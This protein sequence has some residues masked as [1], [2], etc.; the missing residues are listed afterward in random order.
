MSRALSSFAFE[1]LRCEQDRD[2]G[3]FVTY[4]LYRLPGLQLDLLLSVPKD[5]I[6]FVFRFLFEFLAQAL[7]VCARLRD[8]GFGFNAGLLQYFRRFLL[9]PFQLLSCPF[10]ILQ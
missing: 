4:L 7:G 6:R 8:D 10:C 5:V 2:V 9:Q 3:H 1:Q